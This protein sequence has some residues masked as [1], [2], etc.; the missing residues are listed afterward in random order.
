MPEPAGELTAGGPAC[1]LQR[2][3]HGAELLNVVYREA[4]ARSSFEVL[5]ED[6]APVSAW[7]GNLCGWRGGRGAARCISEGQQCT[8][9]V[10]I[11]GA[12]VS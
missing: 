5:I 6:P 1:H 11:C 4:E 3:G 9:C 7:V 8:E 12:C 2:G 10:T